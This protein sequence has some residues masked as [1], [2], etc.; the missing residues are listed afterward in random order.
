MYKIYI[1]DINVR[2]GSEY[3]GEFSNNMLDG[4]GIMKF[5]DGSVY[6]GFWKNNSRS[7]KGACYWPNG[8]L[9]KCT[10]NLAWCKFIL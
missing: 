3:S 1:A 9:V 6:D 4:Q 8:I 5:A 2:T 10:L 7:G